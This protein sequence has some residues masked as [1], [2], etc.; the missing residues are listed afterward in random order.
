VQL[1]E[2]VEPAIL[3]GL[4]IRQGDV[5]QDYSVRARLEALRERL[6]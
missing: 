5:I 6:N 3:G 4:V 1:A 2:E